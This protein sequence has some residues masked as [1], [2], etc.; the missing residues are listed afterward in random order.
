MN[1]KPA[2][3]KEIAKQLN[4]SVSTVSRA[5]HNHPSIGLRTKAQV[6]KLA[7]ELNYEPN[8]AAISFKQGKT[9]T[10]G[11]ILPNLGEEFFST[12]I[13]GIEDIAVQNNYTVLI[14]QSHDNVEREKKIVDTMR[15]HRVDGLLV[16]LSKNTNTYEHFEQLKNYSIP[17]VFFDRVPDTWE[18]YS[19][20]CNLKNSSVQ[21]VDWLVNR[22]HKHIGFIKGPDTMLPSLERLNGFLE[23]LKKNNLPADKAYVVQ[24]DLDKE[25]T[26]AAMKQL[27]S[28]KKRPTAI[29]AFNDY[30]ALDAMKYSRGQGLKINQ[31]IFFVSYANLPMTSYL[32]EPPLASVEQFPYEQAE[33]A[34]EILIQLINKKSAEEIGEKKVVM[35]SKVIVHEAMNKKTGKKGVKKGA[36]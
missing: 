22:G 1:Q 23:G 29:I 27:L 16:S 24:T 25:K 5:L 11:V 9:F 35:Q 18:A 21:L 36:A 8:Q 28:L 34:T 10:I 13:N 31:D 6:Q 12:A 3:I 30:V 15:R 19:V 7:Q 2:T 20:S 32:D 33:K 4:V 26:L 17:V 14:G